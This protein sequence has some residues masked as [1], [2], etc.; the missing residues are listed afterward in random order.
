MMPDR[1]LNAFR[2]DLADARL[3]GQVEAARF[4]EG[5]TMRVAAP[6]ASLR[7]E[8]HTAA[9]QLSQALMGET[10]RVFDVADG[11]AFVQLDR[12]CYVGYADWTALA[13]P[14]V[15][16]T[17]RVAVPLSFIYPKAGIKT[18]PAVAVSMNATVAVIGNEGGNAAIA[19][20]GYVHAA[21]LKPIAETESD[22]VEV[23]ERLLHAPYYWGGKSVGGIDCSGLVQLALEACGRACPR[24]SDMQ[25]RDLGQSLQINDLDGLKRGDLAFWK[26]HVGLVQGPDRLLHASGHHMQVVSESLREAVAR[27]AAS[28]SAITRLKRL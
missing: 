11:W 23:A 8:P 12:D 20:G 6:L 18:Q 2:P 28:E 7:R 25:E 19:G 27:I 4:V 26:G 14:A 21:H 9:V 24:D 1:R 3:S 13:E 15:A 10:L 22:F 5:V 16:A 17:H